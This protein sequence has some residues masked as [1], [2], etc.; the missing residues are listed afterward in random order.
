[1]NDE[2][3]KRAVTV[4]GQERENL[5]PKKNRGMFFSAELEG[6]VSTVKS[7]LTNQTGNALELAKFEHAEIK[8]L[9]NA[10]TSERKEGASFKDKL[11]DYA[12]NIKFLFELTFILKRIQPYCDF[13]N[14]ALLPVMESAL[15]KIRLAYGCDLSN[16]ETWGI[17][18]SHTDKICKD[19]TM[20]ACSKLKLSRLYDYVYDEM[21]WFA[22]SYKSAPWENKRK[23]FATLSEQP[24]L[25]AWVQPF[26]EIAEERAT[27]WEIAL[28]Q[29]MASV[30]EVP[31]VVE[32][33]IFE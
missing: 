33:K 5:S 20:L 2:S 17:A 3:L 14:D 32:K 22:L 27:S 26:I 21:E 4:E 6:T 24:Q 31:Q 1:M 18:Q 30:S 11:E 25:L 9:F 29:A 7:D 23:F 13:V 12:E 15:E 19:A 16:H 28:S 10:K 8:R